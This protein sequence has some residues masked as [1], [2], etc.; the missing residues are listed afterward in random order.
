MFLPSTMHQAKSF[1][2]LC[3]WEKSLNFLEYLLTIVVAKQIGLAPVSL[4]PYLSWNI[5]RE[6]GFGPLYKP[7]PTLWTGLSQV[8][9]EGAKDRGVGGPWQN[10]WSIKR[11]WVWINEEGGCPCLTG[12][13]FTTSTTPHRSP[14]SLIPL[15][16]PQSS[17]RSNRIASEDQQPEE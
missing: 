7:N 1:Q 10:I 11:N 13:P 14:V 5:Y 16:H 6:W 2:G 12:T 15:P 4:E 17:G 8:G 9:V 3:K